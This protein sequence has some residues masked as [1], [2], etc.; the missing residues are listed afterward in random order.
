MEFTEN[1]GNCKTPLVFNDRPVNW[2]IGM[3]NNQTKLQKTIELAVQ[4]EE[5]RYCVTKRLRC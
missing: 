3:K 2:V 4:V 5:I 1:P